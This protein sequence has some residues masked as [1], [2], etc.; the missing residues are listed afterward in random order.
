[1]TE[2]ADSVAPLRPFFEMRDGLYVPRGSARSPWNANHQNGVAIGSLLA[3]TMLEAGPP[4]D[5]NIARFTLDIL[6]PAP[7]AATRAVWRPLR[8]GRRTHLLQGS[9]IVGQV[10]VARASALFVKRADDAPPAMVFDPPVPQ[11]EDAPEVYQ[12]PL[13]TGLESR[14]IQRGAAASDQPLGRVWVRPLRRVVDGAAAHPLISAVLASDFGGGVSSGA[15]RKT[16][17]SPTSTSRCIFCVR[18]AINGSWSRR[19]R[20]CLATARLWSTAG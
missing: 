1:M 11:P 18:R 9:L 6:R 16:W 8:D 15:G 7:M 4:E 17:N 10:E 20:F 14:L 12:M 2:P 19:A 3:H 5:M 13:A